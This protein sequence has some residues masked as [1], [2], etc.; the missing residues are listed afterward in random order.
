MTNDEIKKVLLGFQNGDVE[1]DDAMR[2]AECRTLSEFYALCA[3]FGVRPRLEFT[4][5]ELAIVDLV[6]RDILNTRPKSRFRS[7]R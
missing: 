2:A 1:H 5:R 6:V 4:E 7:V 3:R